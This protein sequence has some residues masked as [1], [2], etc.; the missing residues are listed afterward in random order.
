M[1]KKEVTTTAKEAGWRV[2]DICE[3]AYRCQIRAGESFDSAAVCELAPGLSLEVLEVGE[4]RRVKVKVM[5]GEKQVQKEGWASFQTRFGEPLL[6]RVVPASLVKRISES[7]T[8]R[9]QK[10]DET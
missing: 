7:P 5:P 2:G 9:I 3:V 4:G 10:G 6:K 8:H 1:G